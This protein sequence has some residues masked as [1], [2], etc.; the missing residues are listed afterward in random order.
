MPTADPLP[1]LPVLPVPA[2]PVLPD[3]PDP[4]VQVPDD[5][6]LKAALEATVIACVCAPAFSVGLNISAAPANE[7]FALPAAASCVLRIL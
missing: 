4:V 1:V 7:N 6:V 2:D 3:P 5:V